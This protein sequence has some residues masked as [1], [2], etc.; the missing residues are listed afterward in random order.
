MNILALDCATLTGWAAQIQG[1]IES[2]VQDFTKRRGESSG[3]LFMN[4]NHWLEEMGLYGEQIGI[5]DNQKLKSFDLI[6]YEQAHHRG[7]AATELCVGL[8]TRVQEFGERHKIEHRPIYSGELK[9]FINTKVS[10]GVVKLLNDKL[11]QELCKS[12]YK[13]IKGKIPVMIWFENERGRP[14]IDDNE[15]DAMALLYYAIDAT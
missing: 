5:G 12:A 3:I 9:K 13:K 15:A 14:P 1:R 10:P 11:E 4:F 7:G 6:V 2:G 8:T